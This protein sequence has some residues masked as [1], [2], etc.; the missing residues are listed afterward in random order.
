MVYN[1]EQEKGLYINEHKT[2]YVTVERGRKQACVREVQIGNYRFERV[3]NF[4]YL[5]GTIHNRNDRSRETEHKI[6]DG[7][8]ACCKYKNIM[9]SKE[10]SR[11]QK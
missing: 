7:N 5:G 9:K 11:K 1:Y 6:Q 4:K 2:K 8:R 10:V 3:D